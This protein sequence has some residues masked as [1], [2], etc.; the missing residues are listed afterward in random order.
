MEPKRVL[1]LFCFLMIAIFV[2]GQSSKSKK[3]KDSPAN[4]VWNYDIECVG[5]GNDGTYLIRVW[6][7][8]ETPQ[9]QN[10][11]DKKNAVHGV[12]FR[13]FEAGEGGATAKAALATKEAEEQFSDY[14]E[15]FFSNNGP[16]FNYIASVAQG[17]TKV[18]KVGKKYKIGI[19]ISVAKDQLRNDLEK[20]GIIKGLSSGF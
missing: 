8:S 5:I 9:I 4:D 10:N 6:S 11:Q 1:V 16:Y 12:L 3:E 19:I 17:S 7:Y 20:E 18:I 15:H 13:G 14:F 2:C